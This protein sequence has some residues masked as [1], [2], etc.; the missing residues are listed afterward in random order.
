MALLDIRSRNYASEIAAAIAIRNATKKHPNLGGIRTVIVSQMDRFYP[1][2]LPTQEQVQLAI[3]LSR[4]T[5]F[6]SFRC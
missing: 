5:H 2:L 1:V 4:V 3:D 6:H